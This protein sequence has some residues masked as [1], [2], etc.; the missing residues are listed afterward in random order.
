MALADVHWYVFCS[1]PIWHLQFHIISL[2][3]GTL[4]QQGHMPMQQGSA[5]AQQVPFSVVGFRGLVEYMEPRYTLPSRH[6]LAEVYLPE[7]YS[8]VADH[9]HDLLAGDVPAIS[10]TTDIWSSDCSPVSMLSLTA[11]WIDTEFNLVIERYKGQSLHSISLSG[12]I[13]TNN[14]PRYMEVL[15]RPGEN[16]R[17]QLPFIS[18]ANAMLATS[19]KE[20]KSLLIA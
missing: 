10:F 6:H 5:H 14:A 8:V 7:I 18:M 16:D 17:L 13:L 20:E 9:I 12:C 4:T 3:G 19:A 11:Q 15:Y 2:G 1:L